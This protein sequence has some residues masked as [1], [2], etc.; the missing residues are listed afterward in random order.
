ML[1]PRIWKRPQSGPPDEPL[2]SLHRRLKRTVD[3]ESIL[4]PTGYDL[5]TQLQVL[6]PPMNASSSPSDP[7]SDGETPA[8][9]GYWRVLRYGGA[10]PSVPTYYDA[11]EAS[12]DVIK[13]TETGLHVARHPILE[14]NG[15]SI[16]LKDEGASDAEAETWQVEVA[17]DQLRVTAHTG[18]HE[19][20]V[21]RAKRIDT[22]PQA[23]AASDPAEAS[24]RHDG[25]SER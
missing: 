20:A 11:T 6:P 9:V 15:A 3:G 5:R 18:P 8:W 13:D 14:I 21:G 1:Q 24:P 12:W 17:N 22:D 19:G 7:S 2:S 23:L 16:V 10:S 4:S 25:L